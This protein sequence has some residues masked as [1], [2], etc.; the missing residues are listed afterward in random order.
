MNVELVPLERLATMAAPYNVNVE[1]WERYTG[2]SA[3]R[4]TREAPD[5]PAAEA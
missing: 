5:G 4:P 2:R 3:R 1:R